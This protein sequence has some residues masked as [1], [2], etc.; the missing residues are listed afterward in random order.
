VL[1][2]KT[3]ITIEAAPVSMAGLLRCMRLSP[4]AT[5]TLRDRLPVDPA[6]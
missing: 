4:S 2:T 5:L 3:A 6:V 1:P